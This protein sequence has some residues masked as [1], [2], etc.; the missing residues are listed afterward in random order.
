MNYQFFERNFT[1]KALAAGFSEE[2]LLKCLAYSKPLI[3]KGLPVIFNTSNLSAL[4][5]YNKNYLKRAALSTAFFYRKFRIKKK[6]GKYREIMEPLPSLKDI[7]NWILEYVLYNIP[8]SRYAKAYVKKRSILDNVKYHKGKD[9]VLSLDVADFFTNIK[10]T[11]IESIFLS[12]GYSSNVSNLLAKLCCV[13]D[14]LPQGAPTSPALSNIYMIKFD[15]SVAEFCVKEGIRYTRYADDLT[16]SFPIKQN[17]EEV[18]RFVNS[19]L[20]KIDLTLNRDKSKI[21]TSD[22]RQIVTGIVVNEKIQLPR[23]KRK[24]IRQEMHFITKFGLAE[25]LK[26][27]NNNKANYLAHLQGK[28][29]HALR[30]NP[31]DKEMTEYKKVLHLLANQK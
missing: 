12:L 21:M 6:N 8:V 23:Y 3:E 26:A 4:V 24:Q 5:G 28:I 30:I 20:E 17:I 15:E 14:S 10:L 13:D 11:K 2:N 16:F 18:I 27:T 19:E 31:N 29:N 1:E 7:Q 22:S 9:V 25:H